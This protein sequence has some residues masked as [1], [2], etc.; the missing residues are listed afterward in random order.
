[1][2][3]R[4]VARRKVVARKGSAPPTSGC[5]PDVILFH[6]RAEI[7]CL[8]RT[9][10]KTVGVKA[11]RAAVTPRGKAIL[12]PARVTLP[13]QR[14]KSPLHH[15][16]ACRPKWCSRQ[17]SHPH[18]RRSR[19]RVSSVGLRERTKWVLHL[20]LIRRDCFTKAICRLLRGGVEWPA[21]PRLNKRRLACLAVAARRRLVAASGA[22]PDTA[23][24]CYPQSSVMRSWCDRFH[25][26]RFYWP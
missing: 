26:F 16:N 20:V 10:T 24:L 11:R 13:V 4:A 21:E 15:F 7:G 23:S 9:R 5:R 2:A 12:W 22:A 1:M 14:I 3:R 17:D 8:A 19:R 6:H 18:W 25:D